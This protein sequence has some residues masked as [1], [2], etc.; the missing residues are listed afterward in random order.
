MIILYGKVHDY[1][2]M[3]LDYRNT[4]DVHISIIKHINNLLKVFPVEIKTR[5]V[6]LV[7]DHLFQ[8]SIPSKARS[9]SQ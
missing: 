6:T 7:A 8:I 2:K 9:L 4:G 3:S 5:T 1:L